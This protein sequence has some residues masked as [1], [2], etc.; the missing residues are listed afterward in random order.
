MQ[1]LRNFEKLGLN[2]ESGNRKT[3]EISEATDENQADIIAKLSLR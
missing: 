3:T 2:S 1:D